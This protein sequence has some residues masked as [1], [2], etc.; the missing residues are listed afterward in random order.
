LISAE[1]IR[2]AVLR[3]SSE[4]EHEHDGENE[5]KLAHLDTPVV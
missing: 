3:I 2:F 4:A 5:N 1:Y